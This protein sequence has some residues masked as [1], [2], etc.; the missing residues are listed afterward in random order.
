MAVKKKAA[1]K[2]EVHKTAEQIKAAAD[3]PKTIAMKGGLTAKQLVQDALFSMEDDLRLSKAQAADFVVSF[4][5]VIDREIADGNPV[6]LFGYVKLIPRL[7]TKG[8]R[9][10]YKV[11]G[12]SESGKVTKNYPAKTSLKVTVLKPLKDSLPTASKLIRKV[13]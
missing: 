8:K 5:A 4:Q 12:D 6:N 3:A 9:Q 10:V 11:F 2:P 1:P 7:H 13:G